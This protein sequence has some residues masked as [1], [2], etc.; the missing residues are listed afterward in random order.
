MCAFVL[1]LA[2][3]LRRFDVGVS[4][5]R[6]RVGAPAAQSRLSATLSLES[7]FAQLYVSKLAYQ[8]IRHFKALEEIERELASAYQ[9]KEDE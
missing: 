9:R 6:V 7:A 5:V 4:C 8:G 3:T 2:W 1:V